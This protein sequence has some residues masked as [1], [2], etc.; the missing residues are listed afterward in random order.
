MSGLAANNVL[1]IGSDQDQMCFQTY[2]IPTLS[3]KYLYLDYSDVSGT[4]D[5]AYHDGDIWVANDNLAFPVCAFNTSGQKVDD[6]SNS[7][8]PSA[9]GLTFDDEEN[10]WVS[11]WEN[12]M[13]YQVDVF[14][15]SLSSQTWG[16]IK[17]GY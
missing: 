13:I 11:S 5:I 16:A 10:L 2:P 4:R 14:S 9:Y 7:M 17:A 8:I 12:S 3:S 6:V 15:T 1:Y